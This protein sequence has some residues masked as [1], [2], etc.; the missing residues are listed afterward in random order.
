M[1]LRCE[2]RLACTEAYTIFEYLEEESKA[3]IPREMVEYLEYNNYNPLKPTLQ[4]GV[5]INQQH[6]SKKGWELVKEINKYL[7]E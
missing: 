2:V 5:P 3:K 1:S 7:N 6:F 4:A